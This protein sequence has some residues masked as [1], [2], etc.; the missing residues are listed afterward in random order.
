M[1]SIVLSW[2]QYSFFFCSYSGYLYLHSF[3]T[4]RSSDLAL[5]RC[6]AVPAPDR[7]DHPGP[8]GDRAQLF[9]GADPEPPVGAHPG[10]ELLSV[11]PAGV[12]PV[13]GGAHERA[14]GAD[15]AGM[16]AGGRAHLEGLLT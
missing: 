5:L 9:L 15:H 4:R 11:D 8:L 10:P 6:A 16:V 13:L 7:A 3:P 1:F 12:R 2:L 14:V